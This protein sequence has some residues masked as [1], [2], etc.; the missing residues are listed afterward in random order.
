MNKDK[1]KGTP[2]TW[3]EVINMMS[4]FLLIIVVIVVFY[5]AYNFFLEI[6]INECYREYNLRICNEDIYSHAY[7][8]GFITGILLSF[9]GALIFRRGLFSDG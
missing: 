1:V 5:G 7:F 2:V 4:F 6:S 3:E 9:F 8:D